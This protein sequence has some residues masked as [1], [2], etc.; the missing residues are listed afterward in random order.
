[1]PADSA[2]AGFGSSIGTNINYLNNIRRLIWHAHFQKSHSRIQ[3]GQC[4][5]VTGRAQHTAK[6]D[7]AE[8]RRDRLSEHEIEFLAER[9]SFY[10]ATVG[11]NGWPYVQH[12]GG[13]KGFLKVLD[14]K[15]LSV[16]PI[17]GAISNTSALAISVLMTV[18]HYS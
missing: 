6:F 13:P 11:E 5:A 7:F 1:M 16:L 12:R 3:S 15:D 9:D 4:K 8:D 17:S 18:F 2:S 10:M 14:D